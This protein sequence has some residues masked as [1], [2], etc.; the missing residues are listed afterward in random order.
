MFEYGLNLRKI[1]LK[2]WKLY[3]IF[4]IAAY[5]ASQFGLTEFFHKC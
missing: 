2:A 1:R 5:L 4:L 3:L